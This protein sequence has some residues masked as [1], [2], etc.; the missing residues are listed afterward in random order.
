MVPL[1]LFLWTGC[2]GNVDGLI[3]QDADQDG[4]PA[5]E[6]CDDGDPAMPLEDADCDGVATAEDCDDGDPSLPAYDADCDGV[7]T[8]ED[9]DDADPG[10]LALADDADC[11]GFPAE[12]D[13]D[14]ADPGLPADDADCDGV[15]TVEDCDDADPTLLAFADDADCDGVLSVE[16]CNDGDASMPLDDADCDGVQAAED[17]DD[18]DPTLQASEDDADCDGYSR[19]EDCDDSSADIHPGASEPLLGSDRNCDGSLG[20]ILTGADYSLSGTDELHYAGRH[21]SWAGDVDGDGLDDVLIG[22]IGDSEGGSF[23]GKAF[24]IL[25]SSLGADATLSLSSADYSFV[26]E[27]ASSYAGW[28]VSGAGDVDGDGLDDI[29][30]GAHLHD[31]GGTNS[32]KA[33]LILG[34]SLGASSTIRLSDADYS[35]VGEYAGDYAGYHASGAGDVDGD[36]LDDILLGSIHSDAGGDNAGKAYLILGSSLGAAADFDLAEADHSFVGEAAN[37]HASV[38]ASAAGDVDGDGLGD[39]LIGAWANDDGGS[40]AGK[41][42][43]IL[44]SS[45]TPGEINLSEADHQL[46]GEVDLDY[47]GVS[48]SGA[49]DV[50]G[51]G[52]DDILVGAPFSDEGSRLAGKVYLIKGSSL[53][54]GSSSL[55]EAD[56]QFIGVAETDFAG[57]SLDGAG[58]VDGDGLDDILIG[59]EGAS[60]EA[61]R[62]YLLLSASLGASAVVDLSTADFVFDGEHD[63]DQAGASVSGAGDADGNGL[64]DVLIGAPGVDES[65]TNSGKAYLLLSDF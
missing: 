39:I 34:S 25:G 18:A 20:G 15:V 61:G 5:D 45:L 54:L 19:D 60:S 2:T 10:L 43:V 37:D 3:S 1:A 48:V 55:S 36:G 63:G 47:A 12:A 57:I 42:Y 22:A 40:D 31:G 30:V 65:G 24:L 52:L 16:D 44:G 29:L 11:D 50:D 58:D 53:T 7:M 4:I 26:G 23:A 8:A 21:L 38:S 32:G 46:T 41:A 35:F 33:Y 64:D 56:H 51:D 28:R 27:S 6:D 14:D 49:G 13:C 9:C 59:A 62:L 17:C